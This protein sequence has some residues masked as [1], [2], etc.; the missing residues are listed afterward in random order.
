MA[1][2]VVGAHQGAQFHEA[3]DLKR[4]AIE[5][6]LAACELFVAER[7]PYEL[8]PVLARTPD[9]CWFQGSWNA[10]DRYYAGHFSQLKIDQAQRWCTRMKIKRPDKLI[11]DSKSSTAPPN[12]MPQPQATPGIPAVAEP[13]SRLLAATQTEAPATRLDA[14]ESDRPAGTTDPSTDP[15]T[16]PGTTPGT[17]REAKG[18]TELSS[19]ELTGTMKDL[20]TGAYELGAFDLASCWPFPEIVKKAGRSSPDSRNVRDALKRLK[21]GEL[22][23]AKRGTNG[24]FWITA[25]GCQA[26]GNEYP[27]PG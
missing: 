22:M 11:E 26:I 10:L 16:T 19:D 12:A 9:G 24:G 25:K 3:R 13:D 7:S 2:D 4:R 8:W 18:T 1:G 14:S 15:S 23:K 6:D 20:L 17:Q 27:P 21:D 5:I